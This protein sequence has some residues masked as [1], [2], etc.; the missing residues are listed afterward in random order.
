M[1]HKTCSRTGT[2][3]LWAKAMHRMPLAYASLRA[4]P[5][6]NRRVRCYPPKRTPYAIPG[7]LKRIWY[8]L[9]DSQKRYAAGLVKVENALS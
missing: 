9:G 3:S 1:R 7:T 5:S 8:A 2:S 6:V 4:D